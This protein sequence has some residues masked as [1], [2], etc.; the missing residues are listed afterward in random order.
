MDFKSDEGREEHLRQVRL[1]ECLNMTVLTHH[2]VSP[3]RPASHLSR[4]QEHLLARSCIDDTRR[5]E[6][7][8]GH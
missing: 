7:V 5:D 4:L 3:S 2:L 8:Q 6:S 1:T